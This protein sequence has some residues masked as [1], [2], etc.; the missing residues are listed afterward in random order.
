MKNILLTM[1]LIAIAFGLPLEVSA[2]GKPVSAAQ[3]KDAYG[4]TVGLVIGMY[5]VS[6][7]YVLTDQGYRTNIRAP[8]GWIGEFAPTIYYDAE[9]CNGNA[10]VSWIGQV[11]TVFRLDM[12]VDMTYEER[13][14]YIPHNTQSVTV[15]IKSRL[16]WDWGINQE[17]CVPYLETGEGYPAYPNDPIVTGIENTVYPA[18]MVIE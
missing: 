11:G 1:A 9:E 4:E 6:G 15:D 12:P 14:L 7:P 13:I 17:M 2:K 18:P 16:F 10:Y 3:L 8:V 5:H